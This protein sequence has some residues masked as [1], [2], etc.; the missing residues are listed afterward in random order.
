MAT[1][2]S[3]RLVRLITLGHLTRPTVLS[4]RVFASRYSTSAEDDVIKTQQV[5]A[6]GSG[7]VRV[8]QLNRPKARN[9]ISRHLLDTL[10]K[11]VS[12]IAAE[13]GNGPTRAL[14]VASNVDAAFCA[15]ADLKERAKMTPAE[16]EQFLE[17]LRAT[18]KELAGLQI[19]TISAIS[20]MALGG[21]LELAL[22]THLRVFG[23]SST[24]GL[25]ETR[26][27]IIPGA[28]GTYR[29]PALIGPTR[30]RD[31]ILT[32]RRVSG[33][34][35]YFIGLCDRL[36][37]VLPEEAQREGVAREKVLRESIK[38]A[39]DIC[40]G[41]PIALKQ[42]LL[43]VQGSALGEVAENQAYQGVIETEDRYEALLAF[44]EKRKPAFRGR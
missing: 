23:S 4:T 2:T 38:L 3:P 43:A 42:A 36:V 29:L 13:G 44:V 6:P 35:S 9:A 32:G 28:G 31:L 7:H 16:T 14:V 30:A 26:L 1:T 18:F 20:S 40:E 41:G 24:V 19:P 22:C 34:E 11:Q 25:P 33:P 15:G 10:S 21:G 5:P 27:A 39:L 8:L 12:S 17:K 37:E